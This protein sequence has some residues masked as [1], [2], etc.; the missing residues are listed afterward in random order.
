MA[1]KENLR[2]QA[3]DSQVEG[4][5]AQC[6]RTRFGRVTRGLMLLDLCDRMLRSVVEGTWV[7]PDIPPANSADNVDKNE[8]LFRVGPYAKIRTA[9]GGA[10]THVRLTTF[11]L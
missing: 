1:E 9:Q 5:T 11:S 10:V 2:R 4:V 3:D 7:R 8:W 6:C